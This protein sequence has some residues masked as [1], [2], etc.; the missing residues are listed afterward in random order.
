MKLKEAYT[1]Y[2]KHILNEN[3]RKLFAQYSF[4]PNGM[5]S[6]QDWEL[7][8]AIL[9]NKKKQSQGS[10]LGEYEIKSA[11]KGSSFEYQYHKN[12]GLKK[13]AEDQKVNHVY[14]SYDNN[15]EDIIVRKI[16]GKKLSP[17]MQEWKQELDIN[18][19]SGKQRFRKNIPYTFVIKNAEIIFMTKNGKV[20]K[21]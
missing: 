15:Y 6:S 8:A 19:K 14:I 21:E 7:F 17:L 11:K 3:K 5:I 1:Y 9:F 4:P 2:K 20:E 10:D 16:A 18:Y 13:L 12:C